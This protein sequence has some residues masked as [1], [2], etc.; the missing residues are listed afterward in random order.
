MSNN[1]TIGS[2]QFS[3]SIKIDMDNTDLIKAYINRYFSD[4]LRHDKSIA[5]NMERYQLEKWLSEWS[6]DGAFDRKRPWSQTP[7]LPGEPI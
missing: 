1:M 6:K 5:G 3:P 7:K 2:I 4:D